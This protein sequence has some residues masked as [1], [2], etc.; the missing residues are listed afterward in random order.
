MDSITLSP[1]RINTIIGVLPE[2]KAHPQPLVVTVTLFLEMSEAIDYDD[3]Q[4]TVDYA[5]VLAKVDAFVS[6]HT[7]QLLEAFA[8]R[9]GDELLMAFTKLQA[10]EI[11]VEKPQ[12]F[13]S[14]PLVSLKLTRYRKMKG[15]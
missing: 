4:F 6:Q 11:I 2:E 13:D 12:I 15:D 7:F 3:V 8:G 9:L 10:V 1:I 5:A 14:N